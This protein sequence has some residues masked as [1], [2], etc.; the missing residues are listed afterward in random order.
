MDNI[1]AR[2]DR[3]TDGFVKISADGDTG[4]I[5][6]GTIVGSN[7]ADSIHIVSS[8]VHNGL[9]AGE[10]AGMVFAHPGL[11]E[12]IHDVLEKLQHEIRRSRNGSNEEA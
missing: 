3:E 12:T 9:T 11:A 6:G 1:K 8:F 4:L 5:T 7:A 10:A 2:I